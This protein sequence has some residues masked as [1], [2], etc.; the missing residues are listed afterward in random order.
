MGVSL[1]FDLI[2]GALETVDWTFTTN[3]PVVF[4]A[5]DDTVTGTSVTVSGMKILVYTD[6][7]NDTG[8]SFSSTGRFQ[9]APVERAEVSFMIETEE[10]NGNV[11]TVN[12]F[13][14]DANDV[15]YVVRSIELIPTKPAYLGKASRG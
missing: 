11:P 3:A 2:E 13:F 14:L 9:D 1:A 15:K 6:D 7:R 12:D 8:S 10:C 5:E 4:D